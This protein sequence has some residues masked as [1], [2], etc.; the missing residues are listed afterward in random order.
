[1]I[2]AVEKGR[3]WCA[4]CGMET[5]G[6][7]FAPSSDPLPH[8][9]TS[10]LAVSNSSPTNC[11]LLLMK[12]AN[13]QLSTGRL[14]SHQEGS[15]PHSQVTAD[16]PAPF[17]FK[18]LKP[19]YSYLSKI[20]LALFNVQ[21]PAST[22]TKIL[23]CACV[24]RPFCKVFPSVCSQCQ[25]GSLPRSVSRRAC[26]TGRC[27]QSQ[28]QQLGPPPRRPGTPARKVGLSAGPSYGVDHSSNLCH[29][30]LAGMFPRRPC[31]WAGAAPPED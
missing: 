1:M 18:L 13:L 22:V 25:R 17:P 2:P 7:A 14:L 10:R 11:C 28:T 19:L 16:Y 24:R 8:F 12:I 29:Y 3:Y 9:H 27:H 23:S 6:L 31:R 21:P 26:L 20:T 4:D 15:V 30:R 5:T